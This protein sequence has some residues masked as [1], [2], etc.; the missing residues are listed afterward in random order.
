MH[1]LDN[2]HC[3]KDDCVMT[4]HSQL[5]NNLLQLLREHDVSQ[6]RLAEAT[7]VSQATISRII[8][9]KHQ[10]AST[11]T[12]IKIA[13][14]FGITVEKLRGQAVPAHASIAAALASAGSGIAIYPIKLQKRD[15]AVIAQADKLGRSL[16]FPALLDIEN[17]GRAWA[18]MKMPDDSMYPHFTAGDL[19]IADLNYKTINEGRFYIFAI[20][21][22]L[23]VR[24]VN[25]QSDGTLRLRAT[26]PERYPDMQIN[27]S[28]PNIAM[29]GRIFIRQHLL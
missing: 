22:E 10:D 20:G 24:I 7:N 19:L 27:D 2:M 23:I 25:R 3:D 14:F 26:N 4:K 5:A 29:L 13:H 11:D 1:V 9:S 15:G 21:D 12:L 16:D 18:Y 28:E 8:N 6:N 17:V